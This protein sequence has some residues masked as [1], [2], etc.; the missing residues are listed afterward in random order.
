M[1]YKMKYKKGGFPF[2]T[3]GKVKKSTES[4]HGQLED[5]QIEYEEDLKRQE[6]DLTR[7][8]GLGPVATPRPIMSREEYEKYTEVMQGMENVREEL[9]SDEM[10]HEIVKK[11]LKKKNK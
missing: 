8:H 5:A 10:T 4:A 1:A 7:K 6:V 2:K 3:D 9:F 11:N